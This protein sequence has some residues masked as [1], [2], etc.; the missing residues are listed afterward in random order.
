MHAFPKETS[1][2]VDAIPD[3]AVA[4]S[5]EACCHDPSRSLTPRGSQ[6]PLLP[7]RSTWAMPPIDQATFLI[8]TPSDGCVAQHAAQQL[9]LSIAAAPLVSGGLRI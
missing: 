8:S 2:S 7:S 1:L 6:L 5:P 3:S 4:G 9:G